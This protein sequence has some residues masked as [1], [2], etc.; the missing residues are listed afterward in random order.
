M[1]IFRLI[2]DPVFPAPEMANEDGLLAVGGD[3][4]TNRILHAYRSGIFPWYSNGQPILWW[5]PDPRM[6]LFPRHLNVSRSLLRTIKQEKFQV[7]MDMAFSEVI[8]ACAST[9]RRG[10]IGTWITREMNDAYCRLFDEGYGHSIETWRDG[11]LAGGL[12]GVSLGGVFF[13]ESMFFRESDS[14]KVAL[15]YLAA[16]TVQQNFEMVDCQISNPHLTRL[17]AVEIS[18]AEFLNRLEEGL[19]RDT[20]L[21]PWKAP[22]QQYVVE[23]FTELRRRSGE[24]S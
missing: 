24:K 5:S 2:N 13:G 16:F 12:Y 23:L 3:L 11:W 1:P 15:A 19:A 20:L 8:E 21:G 22:S 14:S 9:P 7:T 18:R 10:E 17:G 6:V 4:T